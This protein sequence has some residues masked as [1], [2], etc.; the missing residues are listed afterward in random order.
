MS[1]ICSKCGVVLGTDCN[2][3]DW[4]DTYHHEEMCICSLIC[5]KCTHISHVIMHTWVNGV[6]K[7]C[8]EVCDHSRGNRYNETGEDSIEYEVFDCDYCDVKTYTPIS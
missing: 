8:A 7:Y 4:S 1:E 3:H 5:S 6:C 2:D